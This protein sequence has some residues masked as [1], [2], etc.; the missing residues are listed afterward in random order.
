MRTK[1]AQSVNLF[2]Y[3]IGMDV[4][5]L[6]VDRYS[7]RRVR[8]LGRTPPMLGFKPFFGVGIEVFEFLMREFD[9]YRFS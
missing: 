9:D 5:N 1:F 6:L 4:A 7:P 8:T 2:A 3:T